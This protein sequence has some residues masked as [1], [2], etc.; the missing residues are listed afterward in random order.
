MKSRKVV[1]LVLS[2]VLLIVVLLVMNFISVPE[3][4][5]SE[6]GQSSDTGIPGQS[7]ESPVG[8]VDE[9]GLAAEQEAEADKQ[10]EEQGSPSPPEIT[11][12]LR[13]AKQYVVI[14]PNVIS[15][16][17]SEEEMLMASSN[18]PSSD[19]VASQH[20][21]PDPRYPEQEFLRIFGD[22]QT[23]PLDKE[24]HTPAYNV[25]DLVDGSAER[26]LYLYRIMTDDG[27]RLVPDFTA[28]TPQLVKSPADSRYF[29]TDLDTLF[30]IDAETMAIRQLTSDNIHGLDKMAIWKQTIDDY[31]A[32]E[33]NILYWVDHPVWSL[34]GRYIAY[35]T[36]RSTVGTSGTEIWV[37]DTDTGEE[38]PVAAGYAVRVIGW[39]RDGRLVVRETADN[40]QSIRLVTIDGDAE[41]EA[42]LSDVD[43]LAISNGGEYLVYSTTRPLQELWLYDMAS[44]QSVMISRDDGDPV[45]GFVRF[46]PDDSKLVY[47]EYPGMREER[48]IV[49]ADLDKL[50]P[51]RDERTEYAAPEGVMLLAT[52]GWLNNDELLVNSTNIGQSEAF[53]LSIGG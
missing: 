41:A 51:S 1:Y 17:P 36:N 26:Q 31:H 25:Q 34:D 24:V 43:V 7:R 45:D 49:V 10:T 50:P 4:Q 6:E 27:V 13:P 53:I 12:R 21:A 30:L 35:G 52:P 40:K 39:S 16:I 47:M 33:S 38:W 28:A 37:V 18:F 32:G 19:V 46:S 9:P 23:E 44:G 8:T 2:V 29:F 42:M 22:D 48:T 14:A 3:P 20:P 11:L 5:P 15:T